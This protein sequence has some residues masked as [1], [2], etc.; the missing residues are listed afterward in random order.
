[1]LPLTRHAVSF[2]VIML[3]LMPLM[4]DVF[5]YASAMPCCYA[6]I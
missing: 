3:L 4:P 5:R 2:F 6:L 1:M